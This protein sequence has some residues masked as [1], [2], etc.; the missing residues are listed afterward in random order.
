M[1]VN[2]RVGVYLRLQEGK[3]LDLAS[4]VVSIDKDYATILANGTSAGQADRI[5][6]DTRTIAAS[7]NDD[8]DLAGVLV[9]SFG[10]TITFAKIKGIVVVAAAANVNNVIIGGGASNPF[11][12]WVTGTTPANVIRPGT[13]WALLAGVA[14]ATGYAVT[15]ATADILRLTNGGAGTSVTYDIYIIGTS[16]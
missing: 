14:D 16:A 5:F 10:A 4:G 6:H 15:A 11:N 13:V 7:S 9:D 2:G 12:T 1:T 3:A 8:L